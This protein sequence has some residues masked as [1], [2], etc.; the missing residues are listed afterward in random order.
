ML[1]PRGAGGSSGAT[2]ATD[3]P[4][5]GTAARACVGPGSQCRGRPNR[6][7]FRAGGARAPDSGSSGRPSTVPG[8][9]ARVPATQLRARTCGRRAVERRADRRGAACGQPE[10]V[11]SR[12]RRRAAPHEPGDARRRIPGATLVVGRAAR[13]AS[14]AA[15]PSP[16]GSRCDALRPRG[17][18]VRSLPVDAADPGDHVAVSPPP[19]AGRVSP[20]SATLAVPG[21]SIPSFQMAPAERGAARTARGRHPREPESRVQ[22]RGRRRMP[23]GCRPLMLGVMCGSL[24]SGPSARRGGAGIAASSPG[25][26]EPAHPVDEPALFGERGGTVR[27]HGGLPARTADPARPANPTPARRAGGRTRRSRRPSRGRGGP[28]PSRRSRVPSPRDPRAGAG[29]PGQ[30]QPRGPHSGPGTSRGCRP[31]PCA[32]R[33]SARRRTG[34]P[35]RVAPS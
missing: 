21:S 16:A 33:R 20:W 22:P 24:A 2:P 10:R 27:H 3:E 29:T 26:F 34:S 25:V 1:P 35:P 9:P 23:A 18:P 32:R 30:S 17:A 8:E 19:V 28:S 7:T 14:P 15:S 13:P 6:S 4:L 31:W 11:R 12:D 5:A